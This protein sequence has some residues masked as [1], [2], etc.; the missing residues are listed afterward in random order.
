[1]KLS[2]IL[3]IYKS[4]TYLKRNL[5]V[6]Y[7]YLQSL[8][9]SQSI[10]FEIMI[11]EDGSEDV[12][13]PEIQRFIKNHKEARFIHSKERLGRGRA[14]KNSVQKL[15]G[16]VIGYMDIDLATDVG[17]LKKIVDIFETTDYYVVAG[18]RYIKGAKCK[19]SPAR[20]IASWMFNFLL[21]ILFESKVKDHQCGFKF[22]K[23][24]F[25]KKYASK[26]K[27]DRW[28]WD[29]EILIL[30]QIAGK[31]VYELPVRWNEAKRS[32]VK[33]FQDSID[34]FVGIVKLFL[35]IYTR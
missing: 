14:I 5:P 35:K 34:M 21:R 19:R 16:T 10:S 20:F 7:R 22:F 23:R 28:F 4:G 32:T 24:G 9:R 1:M 3:P 26:A 18:S 13:S 12:F 11:A 27:D 8:K 30:A 31:R 17:N 29:T 2:V 6:I 15:S 33:L 25:I